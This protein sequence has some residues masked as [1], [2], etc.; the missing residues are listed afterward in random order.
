MNKIR[1]GCCVILKWVT[2]WCMI[3]FLLRPILFLLKTFPKVAETPT[4]YGKNVKT[5]HKNKYRNIIPCE[6]L[7]ILL[8]TNKCKQMHDSMTQWCVCTVDYNRVVLDKLPN[9]EYSDYI[10]A[11]F[12]PVG[13]ISYFFTNRFTLFVTLFTFQSFHKIFQFIAAQ[14]CCGIRCYLK[15]LVN[16]LFGKISLNFFKRSYKGNRIWLLENGFGIQSRNY[17][18]ANKLCWEREGNAF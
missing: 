18:Y 7:L 4:S 13:M 9:E 5:K 2:S 12:I 6:F 10:N 17:C 14:G 11:S 16:P 8:S 3:T 15:L 1:G